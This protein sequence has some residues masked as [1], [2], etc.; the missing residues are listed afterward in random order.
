MNTLHIIHQALFGGVAA[1]GFAVLFNCKPRML[2]LCFNA[3]TLALAIRTIGQENGLTLAISSF[4]AALVLA[5]VDRVW[6][7]VSTPRGSVLAVLGAI[8]MVPGSIAA[9]VFMSVFIVLRFGHVANPEA[10]TATWENMIMLIFT[11][12]AI[13]TGLALPSLVFPAVKAPGKGHA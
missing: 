8:P 12:A 4:F 7:G 6:A 1:V 13:G 10:I 2:P 5:V 9:K 3:G 11:L